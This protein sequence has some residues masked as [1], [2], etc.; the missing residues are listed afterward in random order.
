MKVCAH[1]CANVF[2]YHLLFNIIP[3]AR[4]QHRTNLLSLHRHLSAISV[5][6]KAR[7]QPGVRACNT[8][9]CGRVPEPQSCSGR[10]STTCVGKEHQ[11]A[12]GDWAA[13][14]VQFASH[15]HGASS[16]HPAL[17]SSNCSVG[18]ASRACH[19]G[20]CCPAPKICRAHFEDLADFSPGR[21]RCACFLVQSWSFISV[22]LPQSLLGSAP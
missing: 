1:S 5:E 15:A 11:C 19:C 3:V 9:R 6:E 12:A 14:A 2:I 8:K 20:G 16:T 17:S 13:D 21:R 7:R 4:E 18:R 10:S 22:Q